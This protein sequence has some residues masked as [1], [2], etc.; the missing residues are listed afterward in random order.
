MTTLQGYAYERA[1]LPAPTAN[2]TKMGTNAELDWSWLKYLLPTPGP[3]LK[4][5]ADNTLSGP[6]QGERYGGLNLPPPGTATNPWTPPKE[7]PPK[8]EQQ[9]TEE[10]MTLRGPG[11][12]AD[13]GSLLPILI[14]G[15][16]GLYYYLKKKKKR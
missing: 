11:S 3:T 5:P 15:G 6:S 9:A 13:G 4:N 10:V 12:V 14:V 7:I 1:Y 8:T 2:Q 16:V